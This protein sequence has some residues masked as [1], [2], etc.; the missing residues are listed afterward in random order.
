[1]QGSCLKSGNPTNCLQSQTV[2]ATSS[3]YLS[4]SISNFTASDNITAGC[5]W[6]VLSVGGRILP[7][8]D[9]YRSHCA[10]NIRSRRCSRCRHHRGH[11]HR[12]GY[13][14]LCP[15]HHLC[16][17]APAAS[18]HGRC[19]AGPASAIKR[20]NGADGARAVWHLQPLPFALFSKENMSGNHAHIFNINRRHAVRSC[21][22]LTAFSSM[23][24]VNKPREESDGHT[25]H[26]NVDRWEAPVCIHGTA[27]LVL[28]QRVAGRRCPSIVFC[29]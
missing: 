26:L 23:A 16:L 4:V 7:R 24:A 19:G 15:G 25:H 3:T 11:R 6:S 22:S 28:S 5:N 10:D 29:T 27:P 12:R 20:G 1:M 9:H 2:I 8:P 14:R 17:E 21:F 13:C 18:R